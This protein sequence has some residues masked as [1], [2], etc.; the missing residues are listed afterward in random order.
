MIYSNYLHSDLS[1]F[2][3]LTGKDLGLKL[4]KSD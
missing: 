3:G 1:D 2:L 4:N